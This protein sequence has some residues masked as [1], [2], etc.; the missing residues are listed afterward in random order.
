MV[1]VRSLL[2]V[3]CACGVVGVICPDWV[4]CT[5][6]AVHT[7]VS[8]RCT[9][10]CRCRIAAHA[11]TTCVANT[12]VR[13]GL[14]FRCTFMHSGQP[15]QAQRTIRRHRETEPKEKPSTKKRKRKRKAQNKSTGRYN[16]TV[17][18]H[19]EKIRSDRIRSS[20]YYSCFSLRPL[21]DSAPTNF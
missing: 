18:I 11:H 14:L 16:I 1:S 5:P 20:R 19:G 15:P 12:D 6:V 7:P 8:V 3:M 17:H 10:D 9:Y 13:L 21:R 4:K 2:V